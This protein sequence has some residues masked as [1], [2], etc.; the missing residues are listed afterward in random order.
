MRRDSAVKGQCRRIAGTGHHPD[1]KRAESG[2][3]FGDLLRIFHYINERPGQTN[4]RH[5]LR[6]HSRC[7]HQTDNIG[8]SVPAALKKLFRCLGEIGTSRQHS[9]RRSHD[10]CLRHTEFRDESYLL[11]AQNQQNQRNHRDNRP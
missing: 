1:H 4:H 8:E 3:H 7:R 9:Q 11:A 5:P 10:H 6:K 2:C